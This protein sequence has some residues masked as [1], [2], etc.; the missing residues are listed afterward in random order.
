MVEP[1]TKPYE[2]MSK[3]DLI[4]IIKT[5]QSII[6]DLQWHDEIISNT[7]LPI[8]ARFAAR[9]IRKFTQTRE[10]CDDGYYKG[11]LP[12]MERLSGV[13]ASTISR[14]IQTLSDATEAVDKYTDE[15]RDERGRLE[16][17]VLYFRT[18]ESF[19]MAAEII[20]I[21]EV[22]KHG[23]N[24]RL[25]CPECGCVHRRRKV[26]EECAACSHKFYEN[27]RIIHG[28]EESLQDETGES[29][30]EQ[31]DDLVSLQLAMLTSNNTHPTIQYSK[32]PSLNTFLLERI[33]NTEQKLIKS[34]GKSAD[35]AKYIS[36]D[37][38]H[39][40]DIAKYLAGDIEHMYGSALADK[41]GMT[42]QLD[43]DIDT[44]EE[45]S[46]REQYQKELASAGISSLLFHRGYAD[47]HYKAHLIVRFNEKV[48]AEAAKAY[49]L[50]ASPKLALIEECYPT[51]GKHNGRISWP[52]WQRR[53]N[54]VTACPVDIALADNPVLKHAGIK[55]P[56]SLPYLLERAIN[57]AALMPAL[58]VEE[59][60]QSQGGVLLDIPLPTHKASLTYDDGLRAVILAEAYKM[61]WE[62]VVN[63]EIKNNRFYSPTHEEKNPSVVINKDGRTATDYG[64]TQSGKAECKDKFD[65]YFLIRGKNPKT[66]MGRLID[67]EKQ[68]RERIAS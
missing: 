22:A 7:D 31:T 61:S 27:E 39:E 5:Q 47:K 64:K 10:P 32:V 46:A 37:L 48:N 18:H 29:S 34:T 60:P 26:L 58:E 21:K 57:D 56:M 6:H 52:L 16:K 13:S 24:R 44:L 50:A 8:A 45:Y 9:A 68:Q 66:E 28:D 42:Y 25:P 2:N 40:V 41:N 38:E 35:A 30:E 17:N 49:C 51:G 11:Y 54:T 33:G 12:E 62:E 65:W 20:P 14:G 3:V 53:G 19:N 4:G 1:I 59:T 23:G 43:F 63:G 55:A 36:L 15:I 67:I